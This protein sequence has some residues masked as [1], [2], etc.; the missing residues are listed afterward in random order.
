MIVMSV[1]HQN[2]HIGVSFDGFVATV[3][4]RKF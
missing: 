2:L 4:N 1:F 3:Q